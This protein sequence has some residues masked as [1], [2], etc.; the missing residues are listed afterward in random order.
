[1]LKISLHFEI[2][3]KMLFKGKNYKAKRTLKIRIKKIE[4]IPG[5]KIIAKNT[6]K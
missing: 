5:W 1:M 6:R 2:R 3:E 4:I